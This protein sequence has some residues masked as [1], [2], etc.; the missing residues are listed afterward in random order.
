MVKGLEDKET[1][2]DYCK[3]FKKLYRRAIEEMREGVYEIEVAEVLIVGEYYLRQPE[4]VIIRDTEGRVWMMPETDWM[5]PETE[6]LDS[7]N[8]LVSRWNVRKGMKL[9]LKAERV[10]LPRISEVMVINE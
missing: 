2:T 6:K 8:A 1:I 4:V 10:E 3:R 9:R 5:A 7:F